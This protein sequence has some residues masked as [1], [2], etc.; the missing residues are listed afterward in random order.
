MDLK[1]EF[2]LLGELHQVDKGLWER[3][4]FLKA[5]P[6]ALSLLVQRETDAGQRRDALKLQL[7]Q[8]GARSRAMEAELRGVDARY[9]KSV[10]NADRITN[11]I[12]YDATRR[13]QEQL[14]LRSAALTDEILT[15]M[16]ELETLEADLSRVTEEVKAT[17][18][19]REALETQQMADQDRI[20]KEM[21]GLSEEKNRIVGEMDVNIRARYD[22]AR[23]V[24]LRG[25]V[26]AA[27]DG[28]CQVCRRT[29]PP[30]MLNES[31]S[32]NSLHACPSCGKLLINVIWTS[33]DSEPSSPTG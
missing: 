25:G 20:Q 19:E 30:Q 27:R 15:I 33:L 32:F 5:M 7:E 3:E 8:E 24:G 31:R 6:A 16:E 11:Q 14:Q 28:V 4:D 17:R 10:E 9:A 18:Q 23:R 26:T 2:S 1:R 22:R 21:G 12:Q 13:E 29:I